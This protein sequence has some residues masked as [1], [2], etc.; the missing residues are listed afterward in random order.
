MSGEVITAQAEKVE[1]NLPAAVIEVLPA[2]IAGQIVAA[3]A[4]VPAVVDETTAEAADAASAELHRLEKLIEKRHETLKRPLIDLRSAIDGVVKRNLQPISE[5]RRSLNGKIGAHLR[6][7]E[8]ARQAAIRAAEEERRRQEEEQRQAEEAARTASA[9]AQSPAEDDLF[10]GFT[11]PADQSKVETER[12]SPKP[13]VPAAPIPP[14]A[15][16]KAVN[17]RVVKVLRINDPAAIPRSF[18]DINEARVRKALLDGIAVPGAE[19]VEE[20]DV[21]QKGR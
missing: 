11:E 21:A 10:G 12:L 2:E 9:P 13:V 3:I 18:M 14:P 20:T 1:H 19:L 5:A 7:Q 6:K 17:L 15:A 8:E 4:A 16:S